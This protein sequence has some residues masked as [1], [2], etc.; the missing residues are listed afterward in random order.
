MM[1]ATATTAHVTGTAITSA[2]TGEEKYHVWLQCII[3]G[4]F[5][6]HFALTFVQSESDKICYYCGI[7]HSL[8]IRHGNN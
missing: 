4:D 1:T 3:Y 8:V 2:V 6:F 7:T 5:P